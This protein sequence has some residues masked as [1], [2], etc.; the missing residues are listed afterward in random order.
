MKIALFK[1]FKQV[2]NVLVISQLLDVNRE[3][4]CLGG[5]QV[6]T[7]GFSACILPTLSPL[8][9]F[10]TFALKYLS[11]EEKTF[12][13]FRHGVLVLV[14]SLERTVDRFTDHCLCPKASLV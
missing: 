2:Y 11:A 4:I 12:E 1:P 3:D 6:I 10:Q 7:L 5:E 8:L 9:T 14:W 13:D